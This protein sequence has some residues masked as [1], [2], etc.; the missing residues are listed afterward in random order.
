MSTATEREIATQPEC[1]E[2]AQAMASSIAGLLPAKGETVAVVGCGT[3]WFIAESYASLRERN[4]EGLTDAFTASEFPTNR[5]YDRV[6]TISR[7]GTTTEVVDLLT[8]LGGLPSIA[9]T[10]VHDSPVEDAATQTVVLDFADETSVVQ[11]RFATTTL[12][13]LRSSLRENLDGV[14]A[15]ARASLSSPIDAAL[16][17]ASQFSFL[18]SGWAH[19]LAREAA[20][21]MREAARAWTESYPAMEYRHGPISIAE[22]GRVVWAF[23][24]LPDGLQED[25]AATGAHLELSQRD[26][27]AELVRVQRLAVLIAQA[28]G[29][30]PD[31]PRNLT[32]SVVL[33]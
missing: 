6:L 24:P 11:T 5:S 27:M 28:H 2:S 26:P 25:I 18:G 32:R 1:W 14:L 13:L 4:G 21:K 7:S 33:S 22:P 17:Q 29:L 15:D 3:S 23:G 31:T 16:V 20:L 9:I 19:G 8:K 12:A 30:N 10:A